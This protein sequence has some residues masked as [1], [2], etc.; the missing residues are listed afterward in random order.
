MLFFHPFFK[1]ISTFLLLQPWPWWQGYM[2]R[3]CWSCYSLPCHGDGHVTQD[4][5]LTVKVKMKLASLPP[6]IS[7]FRAFG[8]WVQ[9]CWKLCSSIALSIKLTWGKERWRGREKE[10]SWEKRRQEGKEDE[11]GRERERGKM[12]EWRRERKG[13]RREGGRK[14]T[15]FEHSA[16][17]SSFTS[18]LTAV[19]INFP[20]WLKMI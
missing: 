19:L 8:M 13:G 14:Q 5:P 17:E 20:V 11:G 2:I 3:A 10:E 12:G 18:A 6:F 16:P 15:Y 9:E 7:T 1:S 4:K